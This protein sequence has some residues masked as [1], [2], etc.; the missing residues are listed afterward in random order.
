M[1]AAFEGI[2]CLIM[3]A[4]LALG[5]GLVGGALG[6]TVQGGRW[7]RSSL[8]AGCFVPLLA[9]PVMLGTEV[10]R[11]G[12]PPLLRVSTSVR[13]AAPPSVVWR[14]VV[15]FAELPP[16]RELIFK[17]GIAYPMR[18]EIEGQGVGAVRRC[19]FSTGPFVEPIEV[20]DEPRLL[21]FG[22]TANPAPMEE[23]TPY[24]EVHPP[25][26]E[27][28][29][30]SRRGQFRLEATSEGGTLLEG[31]TWYH[32]SLWPAPYWQWWSDGII[33]TIHRRVL[34]HVKG[35]AEGTATGG[36]PNGTRGDG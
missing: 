32:H 26:L 18:A 21:R 28:F 29:L 4:P 19:V 14:H 25:H 3:A 23:W 33:H 9:L 15:A 20:W 35:L 12:P 17:L 13:V 16:P 5:L 11:E 8:E 1:L 36:M 27:G 10:F 34:E 6:Y 7:R 2:L 24:D 30:V 22:V 31:T